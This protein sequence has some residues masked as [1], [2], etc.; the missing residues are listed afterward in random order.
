MF[1]SV[2]H[3]SRT[4]FGPTSLSKLFAVEHALWS[5][6]YTA[7]VSGFNC[8]LTGCALVWLVLERE[9]YVSLA[10]ARRPASWWLSDGSHVAPFFTPDVVLSEYECRGLILLHLAAFGSREA[11]QP[12][13]SCQLDEPFS[14]Q[15]LFPAPPCRSRAIWW[16]LCTLKIFINL[17]FLVIIFFLA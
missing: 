2:A 16:H 3:S 12:S 6:G 11:T 5:G 15:L 9:A 13:Y 4:V 8:K 14:M 17:G 7:P 1:S 10:R